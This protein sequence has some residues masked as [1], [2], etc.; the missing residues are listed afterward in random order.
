MR[1]ALQAIREQAPAR[2]I[3]AVPVAPAETC[4]RLEMEADEIVCLFTPEP[5]FSIG[6]WYLDFTQTSDREVMD[7]LREAR[8]STQGDTSVA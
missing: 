8:S 1:T 7:L 3:V 4:A 2:V 5:F 6:S